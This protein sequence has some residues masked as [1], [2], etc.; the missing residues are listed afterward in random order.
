MDKNVFL[1]GGQSPHVVNVTG[2]SYHIAQKFSGMEPNKKYRVSY[3]LR[4]K[5]V[6]PGS[7]GVGGYLV[8]GQHQM[9]L[10]RTRITGTTAWHPQSFIITTA[11][12]VTPETPCSFA[13][14]NWRHKGEF[15]LDHVEIV[16]LSSAL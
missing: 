4:L 16:L 15:W 1:F 3:Y 11:P 6:E 10:P 8:I 9:A 14:W 7:S 2:Q 13:V 12:D 5:D